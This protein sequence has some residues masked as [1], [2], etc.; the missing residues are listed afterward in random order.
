MV[1]GR[2]MEFIR[3]RMLNRAV[4]ETLVLLALGVGGLS[5]FGPFHLGNANFPALIARSPASGNQEKSPIRSGPLEND[6]VPDHALDDFKGRVG[7]GA[8]H[9]AHELAVAW[10]AAILLKESVD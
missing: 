9:H 3:R 1:F 10:Y 2:I 4:C 7:R 5:P 8:A 6:A